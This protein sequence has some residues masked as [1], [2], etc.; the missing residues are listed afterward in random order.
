MHLFG[1]QL[2]ELVEGVGWR[3]LWERELFGFEQPLHWL[4]LDWVGAEG[5]GCWCFIAFSLYEGLSLNQF[6]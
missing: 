4:L 1:K 2:T 3:E 5:V 6:F